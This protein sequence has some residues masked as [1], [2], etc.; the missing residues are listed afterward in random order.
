MRWSSHTMSSDLKSAIIVT[1]H[2]SQWLL[3]GLGMLLL[4]LMYGVS[5]AVGLDGL[6]VTLVPCANLRSVS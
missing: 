2:L 4:W 1:S 3:L 6:E 5:P